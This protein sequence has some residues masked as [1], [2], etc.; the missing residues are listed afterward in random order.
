MLSRKFPSWKWRA[1]AGG[2]GGD[3]GGTH[4]L[5]VHFSTTEAQKAAATIKTTMR[6]R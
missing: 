5:R 1:G 4:W 3:W 6:K 2:A